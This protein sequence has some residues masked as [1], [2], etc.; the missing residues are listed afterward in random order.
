MTTQV[1]PTILLVEDEANDVILLKYAFEKAG[2]LTPV[3]VVSDGREA[4]AY[5]SGHGIYAERSRYPEPHMILLD[6]NLPIVTGI[7]VLKWIAAIPKFPK[8]PIVVLTSSRDPKEVEACRA[9]GVSA[10]MVK[11]ISNQQRYR[12]SMFLKERWLDVIQPPLL[13][14]DS[15]QAA[16]LIIF[17]R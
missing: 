8:I 4:I 9:L 7:E 15:A 6:L 13:H 16:D 5:L 12:L 3:Q 2:I 10:F 11:P 14:Y 1:A 17:C